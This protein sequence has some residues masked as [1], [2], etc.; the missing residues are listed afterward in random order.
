MD[1]YKTRL[2][3]FDE[4]INLGYV[5][6]YQSGT[7]GLYLDIDSDTLCSSIYDYWYNTGNCVG[8][9]CPKFSKSSI[10]PVIN[11]KKCALNNTCE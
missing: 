1:G 5:H 10:R 9:I 11:L 7:S 6:K 2:I 8:S 3:T 4:L